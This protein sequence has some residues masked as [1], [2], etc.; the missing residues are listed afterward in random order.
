MNVGDWYFFF[1]SSE[2]KKQYF[3]L[4]NLRNQEHKGRRIYRYVNPGLSKNEYSRPN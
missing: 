2:K 3:F 4:V 1:A